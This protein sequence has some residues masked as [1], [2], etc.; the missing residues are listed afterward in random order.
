M[1]LKLAYEKF[2]KCSIVELQCV[3]GQDGV[4]RSNIPGRAPGKLALMVTQSNSVVAF[5]KLFSV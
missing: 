3:T 5:Q 4:E 1:N 2:E